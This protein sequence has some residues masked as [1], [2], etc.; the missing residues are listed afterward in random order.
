[1]AVYIYVDVDRHLRLMS[2][3]TQVTLTD[4]QHAFLV[5]ESHRTGLPMAE[6]V[7]RAIDATFRPHQ[8]TRLKG[9]EL[10]V[11]IWKRPDAA[12]AGRRI[13]TRPRLR[14]G[15]EDR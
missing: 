8:R 6:L 12:L 7:R 10:S 3:R 15:R 14:T 11:G 2:R 5:D 4:R 1:M 13:R 9:F